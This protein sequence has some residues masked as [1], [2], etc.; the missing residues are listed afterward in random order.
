MIEI[1][2]QERCIGC[3]RCVE[4]CPTSVFDTGPGDIPVIARVQ[5]CQTCFMCEAYCP[6]D[7]LFVAPQAEP[8]EPGSPLRDEAYVTA[9]GLLG[10]YRKKIGWGRGRTPGALRAVG[11]DL[12]RPTPA[13]PRKEH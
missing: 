5:D 1:V 7:A 9:A 2:S 12:P 3:D 6:V 8:V 10:G 4:V 13:P 11:P